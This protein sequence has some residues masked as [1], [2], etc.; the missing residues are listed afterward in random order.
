MQKSPVRR[1]NSAKETCNFIDPTNGSHPIAAIH[2]HCN[3]LQHT[4]AAI[5]TERDV[6]HI[7]TERDTAHIYTERNHIYSLCDIAHIYTV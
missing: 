3:T 1:L 5:H 4:I 2:T 6:A 7:Y